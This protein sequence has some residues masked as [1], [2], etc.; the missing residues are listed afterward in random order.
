MA[1]CSV[2][3]GPIARRN[4][5][6]AFKID[7]RTFFPLFAED[8]R[9]RFENT[10]VA[11]TVPSVAMDELWA[12]AWWFL[13]TTFFRQCL[14][15]WNGRMEPLLHLRVRMARSELSKSQAKVLSRNADLRVQ[16][17]PA[18]IGPDQRD[19]FHRH[20]QRFTDGIPESLD[21]FLGPAPDAHPVPILEFA[22]F[23]H[24]R[25][26]A[27]SYLA[28]GENSVASLYGIFDP[29][30]AD[31]SLGIFTMLLELNFAR[32]AGCEFYYPGYSLENPSPMDYKKRFFGLEAYEW[33][34][35]WEP[36]ARET[37]SG[38]PT[39]SNP[40]RVN[41]DVD[42]FGRPRSLEFSRRKSAH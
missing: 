10:F 40:A 9:S 29:A 12:G 13:G 37:D 41:L 21:D 34:E 3:R 18:R 25:L 20:K 16:I 19:L 30:A 1:G 14:L 26:L 22:V 2:N 8:M 11:W 7:E 31:R 32:Q 6:S 38:G 33:N 17:Q 15:P 4:R 42:A 28:R 39:G 5:S 23:E 35:G 24:G 27:A 36:F